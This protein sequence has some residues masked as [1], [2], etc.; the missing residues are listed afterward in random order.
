[1]PTAETFV[2]GIDYTCQ[3][4]RSDNNT[5]FTF[6]PASGTGIAQFTLAKPGT[7]IGVTDAPATRDVPHPGH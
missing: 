1:M 6:G 4:P 5:T 7:F 2:A 3:A